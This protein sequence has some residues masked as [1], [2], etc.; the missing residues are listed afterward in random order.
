M[1]PHRLS[2]FS[3]A[4]VLILALVVWVIWGQSLSYRSLELRLRETQPATLE[5]PVAVVTAVN[6]NRSGRERVKGRIT[7]PAAGRST[8]ADAF[9]QMLQATELFANRPSY[10][11]IIDPKLETST[12]LA[13][14]R[15]VKDSRIGF[16]DLRGI[17]EAADLPVACRV[18]ALLSVGLVNE[19]DDEGIPWLTGLA[20]VT[21]SQDLSISIDATYALVA[22]HALRLRGREVELKAIATSA[23]ESLRGLSDSLGTAREEYQR[24][25]C[26][27]ALDGVRAVDESV[28]LQLE[29]AVRS[30]SLDESVLRACWKVIAQDRVRGW[31]IA[32]DALIEDVPGARLGIA[33]VRDPAAIDD[34][35][36]QWMSSASATRRAT[37]VGLLSI[38]TADSLLALKR[39]AGGASHIPSSEWP[40]DRR[41]P[42]D[43]TAYLWVSANDV[44]VSPDQAALIAP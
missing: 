5:P 8:E 15:I 32:L 17:V 16:P 4:A 11:D 14:N 35:A 26:L 40:G 21:V 19:G 23:V 12:L 34:L 25:R 30:S 1:L 41:D 37:E 43:L 36:S 10:L 2:L 6:G 33:Q 42:E 7:N 22:I 31:K 28:L 39:L 24:R 44:P 18:W 29:T 13:L 38:G 3:A 27:L 9:L 20:S